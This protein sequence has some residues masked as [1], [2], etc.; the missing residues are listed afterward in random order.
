M[1][2][3][4]SR[5]LANSNFRPSNCSPSLHLFKLMLSTQKNIDRLKETAIIA[6]KVI[7]MIQ[8]PLQ[9]SELEKEAWG[10]DLQIEKVKSYALAERIKE[11][12]IKLNTYPESRDDILDLFTKGVVPPESIF[13]QD[14]IKSAKLSKKFV[15]CPNTIISSQIFAMLSS[16][17]P[18]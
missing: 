9:V 1:L 16:K 13:H 5:A 14:R 2:V 11:T 18:G 15:Y 8:N 10:N 7:K 4:I 3:R 12:L 6:K 17:P